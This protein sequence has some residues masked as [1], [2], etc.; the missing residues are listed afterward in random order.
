MPGL[1]PFVLHPR[2]VSARSACWAPQLPENDASI[3]S[4][5]SAPQLARSAVQQ[6]AA[7]VE[8]RSVELSPSA[9]PHGRSGA[10]VRRRSPAVVP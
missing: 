8:E 6:G 1:S 10:R 2:L 9:A 3:P 5:G 4:T 7:E